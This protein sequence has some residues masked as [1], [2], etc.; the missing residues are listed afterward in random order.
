MSQPVQL[1]RV[2]PSGR[3]APD[4]DEP[5]ASPW[6]VPKE[7]RRLRLA[8][9]SPEPVRPAS[10]RPRKLAYSCLDA[11]V[12]GFLTMM[13][14]QH[15]LRRLLWAIPVALSLFGPRGAAAAPLMSR[16]EVMPAGEIRPGMKGYGL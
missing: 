2:G 16:T 4:G 6:A 11:T 9:R 15:H 13:N 10:P 14:G 7:D 3:S 12:R 5:G 8:V 1:V